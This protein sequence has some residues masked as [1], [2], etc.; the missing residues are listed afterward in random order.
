[1]KELD[2]WKEEEFKEV[3]DKYFSMIFRISLLYLK[4]I[5]EAEDMV[6][7][8]FLKLIDKEKNFNSEEHMKAWLIRVA[9]NAC[10]DI[11][12]RFWKSRRMDIESLAELTN[13]EKSSELQFVLEELLLLPDKYKIALYLFYYEDYSIK[14]VSKILNIK[15]STI[16]T[17]LSRGRKLLEKKLRRE[18]NE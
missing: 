14:E 9:K 12:K 10:K 3:Y 18:F 5:E 6:Q 4:N 16:Q 8:V 13:Q 15:E 2:C 17:Q 7:E 11:N 1:M